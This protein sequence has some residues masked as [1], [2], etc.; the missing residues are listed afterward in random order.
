MVK[1]YPF[2]KPSLN[3]NV[4]Q[5]NELAKIKHDLMASGKLKMK[6]YFPL[7]LPKIEGENDEDSSNYV[8][9][10]KEEDSQQA[11]SKCAK[12]SSPLPPRKKSSNIF[13]EPLPPACH[14]LK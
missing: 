5:E 4:G 13:K 3:S 1:F 10:N 11:V 12:S 8:K 7:V 6:T 14:K 9:Q 2:D